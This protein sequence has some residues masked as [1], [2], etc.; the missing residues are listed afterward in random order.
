MIGAVD[1]FSPY[2]EIVLGAP[3]PYEI[4]ETDDLA[5]LPAVGMTNKV[6][7]TLYVPLSPDGQAVRRHEQ[8]HVRWSPTRIPRV[9]H[10]LHILLAVE[11]ARVNMGLRRVD[12]PIEFA[13]EL[14]RA[15]VDCSEREL[16]TDG[17]AS[18]VLRAVAGLGTN[19]ADVDSSS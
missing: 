19:A 14:R 3:D 13:D 12:L 5:D 6:D 9:R 8:A 2:P 16:A 1:E 18:V 17:P 10:N 15:V 4:F 7:G 11:D